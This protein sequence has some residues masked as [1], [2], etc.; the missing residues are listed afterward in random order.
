VYAL[1]ALIAAVFVAPA[2]FPNVDGVIRFDRKL[3]PPI[4]SG[5][6]LG[7]DSLGRDVLVRL[8][9]GGA[10]AVGTGLLVVM[11]S[12]SIATLTGAVAGFRGGLVDLL[13]IA[14]LDILLSL[15]GLLITVAILGI[16]GTGRSALVFAL[17]GASWANEARLIRASVVGIRESLYFEAAYAIGVPGPRLLFRYVLPNIV[18]TI[19]VLGSLNLAEVILVISALSFL[20]LGTQ[21]PQADWGTMLADSRPVMVSA[22]WLVLAPGLCIVAFSF[23]ANL[24]GDSLQQAFDPRASNR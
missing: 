23:L 10:I 4:S 18:T 13:L 5:T 3:L 11:L 8:A 9:Q 17:V 14:M 2:V 19:L 24:A 22:P 16:F 21:P 12:T 6:I 15:P 7:T 20:G 1:L